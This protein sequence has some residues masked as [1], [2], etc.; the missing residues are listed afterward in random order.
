M[1]AN[2]GTW[3]KRRGQSGAEAA[4]DLVLDRQPQPGE[5]VQQVPDE[6]IEDSPYQARQP[7]SDDS[8]EDLAQGMRAAGFQG[9]VI[10]RPHGDPAKRRRGVVQLV[11]GHRRRIAWR[12]VCAE[13]GVSC[14][15]P[16]V[17]REVSDQ[18]ML[19][20]G[21]QENL[22]RQD[23]DPIEEA[24]IVAW[25]ERMFFDKNQAE[26]GAML[27]KSSDWVSVRSRIHKLPEALKERLRRRPRAIGQMLELA[28]LYLQQPTAA[29]ELADRV[30]HENL[31]VQAV[32]MLIRD[33]ARSGQRSHSSREEEHNR[34]VGTTSVQDVTSDSPR[35]SAQHTYDEVPECT[36]T[37]QHPAASRLDQP[38]FNLEQTLSSNPPANQLQPDVNPGD[39][40]DA[41][42][43]LTL[44]QE[45]AAALASVASRAEALPI[46]AL[47]A[48]RLET[49]EDALMSM[50][51]ALVCRILPADA[52]A[53]HGS[54]SLIGTNIWEIA[55]LL[56][57]HRPAVATLCSAQDEGAQ[58][59]LVMCKLPEGSTSGAFPNASA[60]DLFIA[61]VSA[62]N[63]TL[64]LIESVP[65][66]WVRNRL[67]LLQDK[68]VIV[69][70]LISDLA[71]A[72]VRMVDDAAHSV[73]SRAVPREG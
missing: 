13:R 62:G 12:R 16:V 29:L 11:Y 34:R 8:V 68:A 21:A 14:L 56:H 32:R 23:L 59:H 28:S 40:M 19:T 70:A 53:Q 31:T 37:S 33:A 51:R 54:Y 17:V 3:I 46:G 18:Q 60:G 6:F 42:T 30:V 63:G 49:I 73:S 55:V 4:I 36:S 38:E 64:P 10:V 20:I 50:R 44:L 9:V 48:E 1:S 5:Q 71:R 25:H 72:Q 41:I 39:T 27:G 22:Q 66:E 35:T 26:L 67:Q 57:G 61:V 69:A 58:L 7:F 45:A 65:L 24:Q 15:L 52:L 43:D 2:R 47:T